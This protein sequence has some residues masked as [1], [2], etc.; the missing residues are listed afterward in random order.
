MLGPRRFDDIKKVALEALYNLRDNE[1]LQE[2]L[3][4]L[5]HRDDE[6]RTLLDKIGRLSGTLSPASRAE[7]YDDADLAK[8]KRLLLARES[9]IRV[10]KRKLDELEAEK[11]DDELPSL[12]IGKKTSPTG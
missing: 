2:A 7:S 5:L 12:P 9:R 4:G 8:C 1:A 11:A 3:K 6:I 10:L